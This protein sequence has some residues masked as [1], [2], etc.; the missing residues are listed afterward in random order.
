M[1]GGGVMTTEERLDRLE[2]ALERNRLILEDIVSLM[3]RQSGIRH[4][5]HQR[6]RHLTI[7]ESKST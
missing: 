6:Q 3:E 4:P 1:R 2:V 7:V 5:R